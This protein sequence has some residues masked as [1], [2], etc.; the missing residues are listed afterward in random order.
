MYLKKIKIQNFRN[1]GTKDNEIEFVS[2][3]G[4]HKKVEYEL[5]DDMQEENE[6]IATENI[7]IA[8]VTTLIVGKNNSGKTTIIKALDKLINKSYEQVFSPSDFNYYYLNEC[9]NAYIDHGHVEL[10]FMEFVVVIALEDESTDSLTNLVPFM[11]LEDVEDSELEICIRY[12]ISE[13]SI[14]RDEVIEVLNKYQEEK[15]QL[16]F[17]KFL[18]CIENT[19]FKLNFYDKNGTKLEGKFKLSNLINL[20]VISANLVKKDT[21]LSEAF[22]R[23]VTYRYEH[24]L[25]TKKDEVE[26]SFDT[27]NKDLTDIIQDHHTNEINIALGRVVS[28]NHMKV[29]LS[30]DIT[31]EKVINRLIKY[32]YV[33]K[34]F[35]IPEDQ[36]GLGYTNLM[37]II[38]ALLEYI[39]RYPDTKY[40]NK[41]NL[42]AIEEPET[43]MHPQ[44]QE[45]FINNIN[46]VLRQLIGSKNKH[47][48]SQLI[49]TTHSSHILN[50]KIHRGNSFDNINY[51]YKKD[52]QSRVIKLNNAVVM[53]K[54]VTDE[55]SAE[56][57]FLKKHIKF[58]VSELFFSDAV[59]FVEGFSEDTI[60][61]FYIE[62][63]YEGL[64]KY[65][66]S[67]FSINGAHGFLYRNLIKALGVPT[68]IITDL[69]IKREESEKEKQI[70]SLEKRKTT[71]KTLINFRGDEDLAGWQD[72]IEE[73]NL[74][75]TYQGKIEGYYA[76]SFEEAFILTNYNNTILN[77]V[78]KNL[79]P[80]IYADIVGIIPDL[81]KNK[82][83]SSKWQVKLSS[84][85]GKFASELLYSMVGRQS[86]EELP[87]LPEYIANGLH[88]LGEKLKEGR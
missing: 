75:L 11:L 50:S 24:V 26:E 81:D 12:E 58:K 9:I 20:K 61:P 65:Y 76:T 83:C 37:M 21:G 4:I 49:I 13:E 88:W 87:K 34:E 16:R 32:E 7:N 52:N 28:E 66:I 56:F 77:N 51:V 42:V 40:N 53:P 31:L 55:D 67:I 59:I 73:G 35:N 1:F 43:Y 25:G 60:L 70:D 33:E 82:E 3:V 84:D 80:Q 39:E 23:I 22:N 69:D 8:S 85:K 44:M 54:G 30:A 47:I 74:F 48:N 14:Y 46:D 19:A 41:I 38:A 5:A 71:N 6:Q 36:F 10:P 15:A 72:Y 17:Q 27:M 18:N 64:N 86:D 29:N 45:L 63:E 2:S 57:R 79:K 68:L 62:N 78:L